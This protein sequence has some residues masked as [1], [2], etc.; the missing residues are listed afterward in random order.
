MIRSL[1]TFL[2]VTLAT[3]ATVRA[4]GNFDIVSYTIDGGG[5]RST[6]GAFVVTGTI[7]QPDAGSMTGG[8]FAVTGGFWSSRVEIPGPS[9]LGDVVSSATFEP[10]PDGT[11]NGADLAY[12][13]GAWGA[14]PGSVAD[15]VTSATFEPPPDGLVNGADLALLL[16]AWG[17]CI[18]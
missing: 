14:N 16:G 6:G 15:F 7:G 12:L 5:G 2:V 13:L 3:S 18:R 8:T 9:C 10:P 11:V 4:G 17:P 1:I